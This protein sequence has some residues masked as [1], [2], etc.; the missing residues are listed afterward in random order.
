[1]QIVRFGLTA[2]LVVV[3]ACGSDKST[4]SIPVTEGGDST[5]APGSNTLP[6]GATFTSSKMAQQATSS[7][8][9]QADQSETATSGSDDN[10]GTS[11]HLGGA[12]GIHASPN[13]TFANPMG[14]D[15]NVT[16]N[17]A[18]YEGPDDCARNGNVQVN[19]SH[20][21]DGT[22]DVVLSGSIS[23]SYSN[24]RTV[25]QST[26]PNIRIVKRGAR[27][28]GQV[29][30]EI[31]GALRRT[32]NNAANP[33]TDF[34]YLINHTGTVV[35]DVYTSGTLSNR[36]INGTV[37]ITDAQ[38]GASA[39]LAFENVGRATPAT[40]LCP[41]SGT[42][43]VDYTAAGKSENTSHTFNGTCG[44]V[45][46]VDLSAVATASASTQSSTSSAGTASSTSANG[47]VSSAATTTVLWDFCTP[48]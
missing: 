40:C 16:L 44:Q 28:A 43:T 46:M 12:L 1:M 33:D 47:S 21:S 22:S 19:V 10:S 39:T 9:N 29:I 5:I 30:R 41:T 25:M 27:D 37:T 36:T 18:A 31:Q 4:T 35:T 32:L 24:D 34:D 26:E 7:S 15:F 6:S 20:G 13:V 11:R 48:G 38:H 2:A 23:E 42:I 17:F 14:A 45:V 8:Q 3:A